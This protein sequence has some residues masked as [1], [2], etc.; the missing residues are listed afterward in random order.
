MELRVNKALGVSEEGVTGI[1]DLSTMGRVLVNELFIVRS[2]CNASWAL[3]DDQLYLSSSL[4]QFPLSS[5]WLA[6]A[7]GT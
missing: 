6:R 3:F 7:P 1:M 5:P 4:L 2:R